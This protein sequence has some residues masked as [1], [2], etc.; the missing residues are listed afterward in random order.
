MIIILIMFASSHKQQPPNPGEAN[1][2]LLCS[3]ATRTT[4]NFPSPVHLFTYLEPSTNVNISWKTFPGH[5]TNIRSL[6]RQPNSGR[7]GGG[8][9]ASIGGCGR[10]RAA[11]ASSSGDLSGQPAGGQLRRPTSGP[12]AAGPFKGEKNPDRLHKGPVNQIEAFD[13][14]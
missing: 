3:N 6:W 10:S 4:Q 11:A 13:S 14:G 9:N 8:R 12:L 5:K 1:L 2:F 7:L